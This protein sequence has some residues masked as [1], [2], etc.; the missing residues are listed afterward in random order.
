[1]YIHFDPHVAE[2]DLKTLADGF[3]SAA[4][5]GTRHKALAKT[6]RDAK[7]S[8]RTFATIGVLANCAQCFRDIERDV[9]TIWQN[10]SPIKMTLSSNHGTC[11]YCGSTSG[12]HFKK[13]TKL[14]A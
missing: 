2:E 9:E 12:F 5:A 3:L 11:P 4:S 10:G 14:Y 13:T 6:M 7:K 8:E 1:M